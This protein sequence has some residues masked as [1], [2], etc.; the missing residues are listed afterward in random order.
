[1]HMVS[2]IFSAICSFIVAAG[3][4]T[5]LYNPCVEPF[6]PGEV[7][8]P[9]YGGPTITIMEDRQS[10]Y[11]I[12][13]GQNAIPAEVTAAEKLQ[14][15]LED[16][17]G[18]ALPIVTD[19]VTP[20]DKEIVVGN[21]N[22][23]EVNTE[24]LGEEGFVIK[25]QGDKIIIAGGETRGT[26]YG[27]F[28]FLEKYLGCRWYS[29]DRKVIPVLETVKV[30]KIIDDLEI[31]AFEYRQFT[32]VQGGYDADSALANRANAGPHAVQLLSAPEVGGVS[33]YVLDGHA[34][35]WIMSEVIDGVRY[36]MSSPEYFARH[37]DLFAKDINGNPR[38]GYT[39]P[40]F[41]H[42]EVLEIYVD[43][44]HERMLEDPSTAC[45]SIALNGRYLPVRG[46]QAGLL[47][48]VRH[49]DQYREQQ[50]LRDALP[51]HERAVRGD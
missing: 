7:I 40:C 46:L 36:P 42:P 8:F 3:M 49:P 13:R 17:G 30:P 14:G 19:D 38:S 43:Y 1:M 28:D 27:I 12:V 18:A 26:L 33:R 48:G 25:T 29:N 4:F 47:R 6:T 45:I 32:I 15:F 31:P 34:G 37:S 16:I 41:S 11:V 39:N 44:V 22:R 23:F 21:T 51:L 50:L 24:P 20:Q 2:K 10:G 9:A 5:G 35:N